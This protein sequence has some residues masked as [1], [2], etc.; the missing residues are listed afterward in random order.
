MHRLLLSCPR[1]AAVSITCPVI[2][3]PLHRLPRSP[4]HPPCPR[5]HLGLGSF[6]EWSEAKR[7]EFLSAELASKRPL[8]PP[9]MPFS[10][11][12]QEVIDTLK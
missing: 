7:L 6:G 3:S 9:A 4:P 10:P 8:I 12:A 11:D 2:N 1:L 5:R